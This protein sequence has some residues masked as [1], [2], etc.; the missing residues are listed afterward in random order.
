MQPL[1]DSGP[2]NSRVLVNVPDHYR[3]GLQISDPFVCGL[4]KPLQGQAEQQH[5]RELPG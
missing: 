2:S 1:A 3:I 5:K 4:A